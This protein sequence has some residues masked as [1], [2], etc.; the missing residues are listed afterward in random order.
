MNSD[1]VEVGGP[2]LIEIANLKKSYYL[3]GKEI[4][5]LT[6]VD[7]EVRAG[8]RISI[9]GASGSGKSTFLHILGTLDAPDEGTV[10]FEGQ[11]VFEKRSA[12]LAAFRNRTIGFVFQFHHLLPEFSAEENVMMPAL[13]QR[14]PKAE[15]KRRAAQM[16]DMVGLSHRG[17]HRPGELSGGEQQRVA[18][19]RAL[20]LGP[21]LL[22]ADEPTGNLDEET[23]SGIHDLLDDMNEKTGLT[24]VLV[25]HSTRLAARMPRRLVMQGGKLDALVPAESAPRRAS[26]A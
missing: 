15:A 17:P 20:V 5:V 4:P 25:T 2:A 10:R 14:M 1:R 21:R 12:A 19:A 13:I 11:D 7:V 8:E 24:V 22:L 23:A 3:D 18:I 6:G 26:S 9:T 16:L